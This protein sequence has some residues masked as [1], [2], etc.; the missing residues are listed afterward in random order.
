V[1]IV[2]LDHI[3]IATAKL[4]ET[5]AFYCDV[6]GLIEGYRPNFSVAGHWLYV[7]GSPIVHLQRADEGEQAVGALRHFA[8]RVSDLDDCKRR[9]DE[10][11]IAYRITRTPDGAF[12]QAFLCD[13]SGAQVEL[14][15]RTTRGD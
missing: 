9:L 10:R 11:D 2:G 6:L 7:G 3:N 5:R 13:P 15:C 1:S 12:D 14:I 8:L 4:E